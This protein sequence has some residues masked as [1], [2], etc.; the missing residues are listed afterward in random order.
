MCLYIDSDASYMLEPKAHSR[1][2]HIFYLSNIPLKTPMPNVP[3]VTHAIH[4]LSNILRKDM[5]TVAEAKFSTMA[6][7]LSV[8][9]VLMMRKTSESYAVHAPTLQS[10]SD[11]TSMMMAKVMV[12]KRVGGC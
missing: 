7:A 3:S 2:G 5:A 11:G 6:M 8:S 4:I 1:I 10:A 12:P 9:Y